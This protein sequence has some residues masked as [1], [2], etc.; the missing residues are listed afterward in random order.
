MSDNNNAFAVVQALASTQP[1]KLMTKDLDGLMTLKSIKM[2]GENRNKINASMV[3]C[4]SSHRSA[5]KHEK[6]RKEAISIN[7]L[8]TEHRISLLDD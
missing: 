6:L 1:P 5:T 8:E 7:T 4:I 3:N 2:Y